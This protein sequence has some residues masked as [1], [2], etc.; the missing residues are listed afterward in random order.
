MLLPVPPDST[1]SYIVMQFRVCNFCGMQS[2][3]SG[4]LFQFV[5]LQQA[6][7]TALPEVR[8]SPPV[9]CRHWPGNG[10][11]HVSGS[12]VPVLAAGAG[13]GQLLPPTAAAGA[14]RGQRSLPSPLCTSSSPRPSQQLAPAAATSRALVSVAVVGLFFAAPSPQVAP[15]AA[16]SASALQASK[17]Y[18]WEAAESISN[19]AQ[20]CD[21]ENE[22]VPL[23]CENWRTMRVSRSNTHANLQDSETREYP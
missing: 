7:K 5:S 16:T 18:S 3:V 22:S 14:S 21:M 2:F 15:A 19:N 1:V 17:F 13:C 23:Q 10:N 4:P 20:C 11:G 8:P 9:R 12:S 6:Y